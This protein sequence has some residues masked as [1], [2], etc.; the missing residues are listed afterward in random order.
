MTGRYGA[1]HQALRRRMLP[2]AVGSPCVRCG[3]LIGPGEPID[4]DHADDGSGRYLGFAH[5]HCN[6]AAGASRGNAMRKGTTM[7][8]AEWIEQAIGVEIS[9]DRRHTSIVAAGQLDAAVVFELVAYLDGVD[10]VAAVVAVVAERTTVATVVDSRS[11]GATLIEPL[12]AAGV[13]LLQ[14]STHDVAVAHGQLIDELRAGRLRFAGHV[15][16]DQAAQHAL[17]R[18]LA[19]GEALERRRVD[20]DA[21][22]LVA[23]ELAVWGL[24]RPRPKPPR[25]ARI[26]SF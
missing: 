7:L 22:P 2:S 14:P 16:L 26:Y 24:L 20:A 6:R 21:S 12:T 10:A 19:G 18:P 17:A 1:V 23:A 15:A 9:A 4:L 13:Q 11:P 25:L 8:R 5:A 3:D